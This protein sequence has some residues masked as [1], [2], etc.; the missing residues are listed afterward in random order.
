MIAAAARARGGGR[1]RDRVGRRAGPLVVAV[2]VAVAVAAGALAACERSTEIVLGEDFRTV[3]DP[4]PAPTRAI[5]VLLVVDTSGSM[6]PEQAA[7]V[8]AAG[9]QLFAQLTTDLGEPADLHLAV[10]STD[11]GVGVDGVPGCPATSWDGRFRVGAVGA[12]CPVQGNFLI[13]RDDG[14]GGRSANYQG[15]LG[16]AFACAAS[17]GVDGCGF[18]QPLE[19]VRRA[20]DGRHPENAGFRRADA[21]LLVLFLTDEDDC[22]AFDPAIY[23]DPDAGPTSPLGP[24][25]SFRCFEFGVVCDPDQPRTLGE[26]ARCRPRLDSPYLTP[27]TAYIEFLRGLTPTAGLVMLAGMYGSI[28]PV[29]VVPDPASPER[30]SLE[31]CVAPGTDVEAAPAVRLDAVVREFPSRAVFAPLC[32]A[33]MSQ[34]LYRVTRAATGVMARRPCLFGELGTDTVTERCRAFAVAG[35]TRRAVERCDGAGGDCF[36]IAASPA[37]DYTPSGLAASYRGT[38]GAGERLVVECLARVD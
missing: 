27:P 13:D 37:C 19:A 24:R 21:L 4:L 11:V 28:D 32:E 9:D 7:L 22:S 31:P 23:G 10:I 14:A 2:A 30:P 16:E 25:T 20:L 8:A 1:G 33:P 35:A 18:E 15:T 12:T 26:K 34:R 3:L 6:A 36:E 5:D 29:V 38:L 17:L